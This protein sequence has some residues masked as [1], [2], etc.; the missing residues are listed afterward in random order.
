[1]NLFFYSFI[2]RGEKT[3]DK[4]STMATCGIHFVKITGREYFGSIP[5]R[6]ISKRL[7]EQVKVNPSELI[8]LRN[9]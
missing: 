1:M 2:K 6:K 3:I 5:R 8:S 9:Q 7:I 4:T